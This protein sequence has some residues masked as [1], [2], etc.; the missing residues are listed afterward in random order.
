[1]VPTVEELINR[2]NNLL[3]MGFLGLVGVDE[4]TAIA[5]EGGVKGSIDEAVIG[6]IG[7]G[8]IAWYWRSRH[9]RSLIPLL[10]LGADLVM[11]VLALIIEDPDDRGDDFG[12]G[13]LFVLLAVTWSVIY[14][15]TKP[16]ASSPSA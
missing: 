14:Y 2:G 6:L 7:L 12:I 11:K 10:F 9:K 1:M 3:M 5:T 13:I 16:A 15:R 4:L 8:A